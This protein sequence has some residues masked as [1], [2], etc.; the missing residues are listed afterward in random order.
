MIDGLTYINFHTTAN[1]GGELRGQILPHATAVPL[2]VLMN[3]EAERPAVTTGGTGNGT[4]LLEGNTLSFNLAYSGLSGVANNA[5]IHGPT[6]TTQSAGVLVP[7]GPFNGGAYGTAG[8]FS[9]SVTLTATQRDAIL[10]GLTYVNIHTPANAPGEIRG[11]IAPVLMWAS[12]SGVN[13]RNTAAVTPATGAGTFALVR[14][15]LTLNVTYRDLLSSATASHIHGPAS[16]FQ[17]SGVLSG[18]DALNGGSYNTAGGVSG[19]VLLVTSNLLSVIDGSTYVNFHTTNY[20]TA[21]KS[22]A[23]SCVDERPVGTPLNQTQPSVLP[24]VANRC[25]G[26]G[27]NALDTTA[28]R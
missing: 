15:R 27:L 11:Q 6:N 25:V 1:P 12:L 3:G 24:P 4:F 16:L 18:L 14:D 22:A 2:T 21:A 17:S 20:P 23:R 10:N 5:H 13:E 26:G 7:L 28:E 9:G 19:T 8:T